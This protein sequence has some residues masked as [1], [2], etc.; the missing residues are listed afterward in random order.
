[1]AER[2]SDQD[3]DNVPQRK[4]AE[5]Q[6]ADVEEARQCF[7]EVKAIINEG[8]TTSPKTNKNRP[9]PFG[10]SQS[11][12]TFQGFIPDLD[13]YNKVYDRIYIGNG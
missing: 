9:L 13:P 12:W 3:S 10:A 7:T 2:A 11:V 4:L 1:M 8:K 5:S 6:D